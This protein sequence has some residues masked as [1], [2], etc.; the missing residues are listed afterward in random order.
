MTGQTG[1]MPLRAENCPH[2]SSQQEA[3]PPQL[4]QFFKRKR[5]RSQFRN[6]TV[7]SLSKVTTFSLR[8]SSSRD[9]F[10]PAFANL[11]IDPAGQWEP[12]EYEMGLQD[13]TRQDPAC[14][15]AEPRGCV[16]GARPPAVLHDTLRNAQMTS[17][18]FPE[19][20]APKSANLTFSGQFTRANEIPVKKMTAMS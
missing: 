4:P 1:M 13:F 5:L 6:L 9:H 8:S 12:K 10:L 17:E 14:R 19:W 20:E 11:K 16:P 3:E 18:S 2:L 15:R 7:T